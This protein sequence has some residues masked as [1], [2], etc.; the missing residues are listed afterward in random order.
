MSDYNEYLEYLR[1]V[2]NQTEEYFRHREQ[3]V[4]LEADKRC[5]DIEAKYQ[6]EIAK[7]KKLGHE[8]E[9]GLQKLLDEQASA[10]KNALSDF[11]K[12]A[13]SRERS[14]QAKIDEIRIQ[15]EREIRR[16]EDEYAELQRGFEEFVRKRIG[17]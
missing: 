9:M 16:R 8:R 7:L 6:Q 3:S 5:K 15:Y 12:K 1:H 2:D 14:M 13:L 17:K 4:R 11:E 10:A